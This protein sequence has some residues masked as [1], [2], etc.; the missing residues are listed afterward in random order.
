MALWMIRAGRHGEYEDRFLAS[1][2]IY[3]TW[4]DTVS[5]D[6]RDVGS[7]SEIVQ[8]LREQWPNA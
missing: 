6:K 7:R 4:G 5:T 2:R 1:S 8:T 3:L